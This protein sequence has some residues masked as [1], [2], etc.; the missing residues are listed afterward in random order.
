MKNLSRERIVWTAVVTALATSASWLAAISVALAA[1][2]AAA[3]SPEVAVASR[4]LIR[5]AWLLIR[6][7][8]PAVLLAL[9][10]AGVIALAWAERREHMAHRG[11]HHA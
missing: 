8:A 5:V 11:A 3:V 7:A 6:E 10:V 2:Q 1:R 4:A 9:L